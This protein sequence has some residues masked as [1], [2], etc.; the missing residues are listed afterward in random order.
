MYSNLKV[1][2]NLLLATNE[3]PGSN[4]LKCSGSYCYCLTKSFISLGQLSDDQITVCMRQSCQV[5]LLSPR[6]RFAQ[7]LD[8]TGS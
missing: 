8:L 7:V 3:G 2:N 5:P 4:L 6:L 1:P